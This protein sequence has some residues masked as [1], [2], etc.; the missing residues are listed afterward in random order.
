ME[1]DEFDGEETLKDT[2]TTEEE[3]DETGFM[4]GYLEE[5][6]AKE[7]AQNTARR[8]NRENS[9]SIDNL[10]GSNRSKINKVTNPEV[11]FSEMDKMK[12]RYEKYKSTMELKSKNTITH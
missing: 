10:I 8:E 5:D 9:D 11:G 12:N 1:E 7:E 6:E 3:E 4:Q 2:A